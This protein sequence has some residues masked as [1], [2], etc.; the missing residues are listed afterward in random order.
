MIYSITYQSLGV[1]SIPSYYGNEE[2][3]RHPE[4]RWMG[5]IAHLKGS[6]NTKAICA[7]FI[8]ESEEDSFVFILT[9][10]QMENFN[11]WLEKEKL[12]ELEVYRMP[13]PVTNGNHPQN[14]RN[15]TLVVLC[16]KK[17]VWRDMFETETESV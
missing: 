13:Q 12:E 5:R 1:A 7:E 2:Y 14:G 3:K 16:S 17:H 15:L 6:F 9:N 4:H 10:A 11:E 8:R